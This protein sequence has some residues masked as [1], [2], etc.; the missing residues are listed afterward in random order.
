VHG[1]GGG[2]FWG[3][4]NLADELG[5]EQPVYG[6]KSRGLEGEEELDSIEALDEAYLADLFAF[7]PHGPYRLGRMVGALCCGG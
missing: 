3:Y 6:F 2:V 1:A 4:S 7:Q 5:M